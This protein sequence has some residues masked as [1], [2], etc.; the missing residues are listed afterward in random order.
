MSF[1]EERISEEFSFGSGLDY[2]FDVTVTVTATGNEHIKRWHPYRR[3]MIS[4]SFTNKTDAWLEEY[5]QDLFDRSGGIGGGFRW[6]NP[7]DFSTNGKTGV[8]TFSDQIC[9]ADGATFQIVRWYGTQGDATATRSRIRKPVADSWLIGIRDDEG[10]D[11]Q[12]LNDF[13]VSPNAVRWT[14]DTYGAITFAD[15]VSRPI[16]GITQAAQAIAD[17]GA[18]HGV[19]VGDSLHFSGVAGMVEINGLRGTVTAVTATTATVD[20]D[21]SGF[22]PFSLASPNLA[23]CNT[24]PQEN[25][26]PT[27]GCYFDVPVRFDSSSTKSFANKNASDV[28]VSNSI[29]L[30]ELLDPKD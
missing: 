21:S 1:I 14:I 16:N 26:L 4:L 9:V 19:I 11:N 18:A 8:P 2:S 30:I 10:N 25:E 20:I 28:I 23:V 29:T 7:S 3:L 5:I 22:S 6:K 24:A 17:L 15:N 13:T 12:I 27:A